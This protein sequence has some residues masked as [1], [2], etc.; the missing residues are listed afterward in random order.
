MAVLPAALIALIAFGFMVRQ[1]VTATNRDAWAHAVIDVVGIAAVKFTRE[2]EASP[3]SVDDLVSA[4]F[5][6]V[7]R[8]DGF[9]R[10]STPP[11]FEAGGP[12]IK[13]LSAIQL[14]FPLSIDGWRLMN[15][16]LI[17][18]SGQEARLPFIEIAGEEYLPKGLA[19][20]RNRRF[21][22]EWFEVM[23]GGDPY[24]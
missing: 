20:R 7:E 2:S 23:Q 22:R 12:R 4:G 14:H 10:L 13:S 15:G 17:D 24:D 21:A 1:A 3:Q 9:M 16:S 5:L 18:G 6:I 8:E 19:V 11:P